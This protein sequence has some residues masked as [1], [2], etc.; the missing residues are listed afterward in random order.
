MRVFVLCFLGD[1]NSFVVSRFR[2][3]YPQ[4]PLTGSPAAANRQDKII[5]IISPPAK[6][7]FSDGLSRNT[8]QKI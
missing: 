7:R 3:Q 8:R 5:E 6:D 1:C 2:S 4:Y